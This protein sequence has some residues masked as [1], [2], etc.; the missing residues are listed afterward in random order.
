MGILLIE[1]FRVHPGL[2]TRAE[3]AHGEA[4]RRG[5][6]TGP[7]G[8]GSRAQPGNSAGPACG[9]RVSPRVASGT[10]L[11][12]R[13]VEPGVLEQVLLHLLVWSA[14]MSPAPPCRTQSDRFR[15][16]ARSLSPHFGQ[17]ALDRDA[18]PSSAEL[19]A[20]AWPRRRRPQ[21]C[22]SEGC[23]GGSIP[24]RWGSTRGS[25]FVRIAGR[26]GLKTTRA[27]VMI[28][29]ALNAA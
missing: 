24:A 4:H 7:G 16:A 12:E 21:A 15:I 27:T 26:D 10:G 29:V 9:L 20:Y 25:R 6:P 14:A 11:H 28:R 13:R 3:A 18:S 22:R 19:S 1:Q 17:G 5:T 8:A 23:S 2:Q